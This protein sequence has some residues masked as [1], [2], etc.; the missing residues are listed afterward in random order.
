MGRKATKSEQV[1]L[2]YFS[3]RLFR[4]GGIYYADG[5]PRFPLRSL[6]TTDRHQALEQLRHLDAHANEQ[7]N[8][9][10]V[11]TGGAD[12]GVTIQD[13][14]DLYL[15]SLDT[16]AVAGGVAESSRTRYR[17]GLTLLMQ[18]SQ[19]ENIR[20]WSQVND[21]LCMKFIKH[22]GKTSKRRPNGYA[23]RTAYLV[24]TCVKQAQ[25]FLIDEGHLEGT[26]KLRFK[27]VRPTET[28]RF[29]PTHRE[30]EGIITYCRA[31]PK[32]NWLA[33]V[34]VALSVTGMRIGELAALTWED[35]ELNS[36]SRRLIHIRDES[37]ARGGGGTEKRRTTKGKRSRVVPMSATLAALLI[38]RRK[39]GN[40]QVFLD[41]NSKPLDD[42]KVLKN[43]K[44]V[45]KHLAAQDSTPRDR[46][47]ANA[48]IHSL[49]HYFISE[50]ASSGKVPEHVLMSWVGHRDSKLV[51]LYFHLN[52]HRS[53]Q[54]MDEFTLP[55]GFL[56][57][58]GQPTGSI[59]P[60]P[61]TTAAQPEEVS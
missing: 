32:L 48:V 5:R 24:G 21:R 38:P 2:T 49:R 26:T 3:W 12:S 53:Q 41:E 46:S 61:S 6:N 28:N 56:S 25:K 4:R 23:A 40:H 31:D 11:G 60:T 1:K 18:F 19:Q 17:N 10:T 36:D 30:V 59:N 51:R 50:V 42:G 43:F 20:F 57:F 39:E 55:K 45:V 35:I 14:I 29:C 27:I 16:S 58:S 52:D 54:F 33:D 22:L 37:F 7:V 8:P 15:E 9:A 13:G 34:V 44:K 47:L